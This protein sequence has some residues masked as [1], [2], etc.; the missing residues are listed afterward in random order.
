MS[1]R[2]VQPWGK[3]PEL[4]MS[5]RKLFPTEPKGTHHR[6]VTWDSEDL[7]P[8]WHSHDFHLRC[9]TERISSKHKRPLSSQEEP[10]GCRTRGHMGCCQP[11]PRRC[12]S[13]RG[14]LLT[15]GCL[16]FLTSEMGL[17]GAQTKGSETKGWKWHARMQSIA[18]RHKMPLKWDLWSLS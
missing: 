13:A 11:G 12:G 6:T 18:I 8:Y 4:S 16:S 3:G 1:I 2:R 10:K 15:A 7:Q 5:L 9:K 14:A 17:M